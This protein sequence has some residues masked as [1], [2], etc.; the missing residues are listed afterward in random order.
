[1]VQV[2]MVQESIE[3][4]AV[5]GKLLTSKRTHTK[6]RTS[7]SQKA[8]RRTQRDAQ[9]RVERMQDSHQRAHKSESE[10]QEKNSRDVQVRVTSAHVCCPL[11]RA[12]AVKLSAGQFHLSGKPRRNCC[13]AFP[14][15]VCE[16]SKLQCIARLLSSIS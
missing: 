1:M 6:G 8:K 9:V 16:P 11:R 15:L 5:E 4:R 14:N 10:D 7:P 2:R 12:H 13:S 3:F